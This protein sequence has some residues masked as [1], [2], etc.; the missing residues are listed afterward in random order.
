MYNCKDLLFNVIEKST[1]YKIW[2]IGRPQKFFV[3]E[4]LQ[5]F[6][7][8]SC[9]MKGNQCVRMHSRGKG[10]YAPIVIKS[11]HKGYRYTHTISRKYC[12]N[13]KLYSTAFIVCISPNTP[14]AIHLVDMKSDI[15]RL[16]NPSPIKIVWAILKSLLSNSHQV[17]VLNSLLHCPKNR[18]CDCIP[19]LNSM[20]F[21]AY[22]NSYLRSSFSYSFKTSN[23]LQQSYVL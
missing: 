2:K 16:D 21:N 17:L 4:L 7:D 10:K 3:V 9:S 12:A 13:I 11:E 18:E 23:F 20:E 5:Q 8:Y 19:L 6:F 15:V 22:I 14:T 1:Y